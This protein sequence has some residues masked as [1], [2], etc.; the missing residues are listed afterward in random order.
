[1]R[2]MFQVCYFS[3]SVYV[4]KCILGKINLE[5]ANMVLVS[6][7]PSLCAG[8]RDEIQYPII[9]RV[10]HEILSIEQQMECLTFLISNEN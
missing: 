5:H 8:T 7:D 1:M 4:G 6:L 2:E 10:E 9:Y 3:V